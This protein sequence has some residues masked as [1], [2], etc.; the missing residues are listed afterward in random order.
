MQVSVDEMEFAQYVQP[1]VTLGSV[2]PVAKSPLENRFLSV[3]AL[4]NPSRARV[5]DRER[6][7]VIGEKGVLVYFAD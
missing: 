3:A 1:L 6:I 4:A 5:K 7:I 2:S